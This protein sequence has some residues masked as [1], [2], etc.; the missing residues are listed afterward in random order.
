MAKRLLLIREGI[1]ASCLMA[2]AGKR[3]QIQALALAIASGFLIPP[4][5][6]AIE[7]ALILCWSFAESILDLR[8]L[9]H[10]GRVPLTKTA[11]TWQLSLENLPNL[12]E[13]LDSQRR[14]AKGGMSYEDY[15]QVLL[16]SKSK[17]VKLTRG[18]DMIEVE[19]RSTKG[20]EG[21]QEIRAAT[22][23]PTEKRC[24]KM[25][26]QKEKDY[27]NT[28]TKIGRKKNKKNE[29]AKKKRKI[30][31]ERKCSL[32][33]RILASS[34]VRRISNLFLNTSSEKVSF[35]ALNKRRVWRWKQHLCFL[36]FCWEW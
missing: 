32:K 26:F 10:G 25:L 14:D 11:A 34:M 4:A 31:K 1:N 23:R 16:L 29:T 21:F 7:A 9:F 20:K 33:N 2:D 13:G 12:L 30:K 18:M 17:A 22:S 27:G 3:A 8:E 5:A 36:C 19:I 6:V 35:C 24:R 15:L 28:I